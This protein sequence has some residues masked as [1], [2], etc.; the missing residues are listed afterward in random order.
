MT[1]PAAEMASLYTPVS[2]FL[3]LWLW[4]FMA[5]MGITGLR[6]TWWFRRRSWEPGAVY[7]LHVAVVSL[8]SPVFL[9]AAGAYLLARGTPRAARWLV[10]TPGDGGDEQ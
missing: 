8:L 4:L 7:L 9:I 10:S 3:G 1:A 2:A 5:G 6:G